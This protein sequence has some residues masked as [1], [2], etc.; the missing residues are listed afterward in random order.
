MGRTRGG[1]LSVRSVIPFL[2]LC[3]VG[4]DVNNTWTP[5]TIRAHLAVSGW[6]DTPATGDFLGALERDAT[7]TLKDCY[8]SSGSWFTPT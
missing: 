3:K 7:V 4:G 5:P 8:I 6:E 2:S 1:K